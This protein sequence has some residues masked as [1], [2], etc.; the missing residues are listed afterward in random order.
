MKQPNL[1]RSAAFLNVAAKCLPRRR[2]VCGFGVFLVT[3][4][5]VAA[6]PAN[7]QAS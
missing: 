3:V 2:I 1:M 7:L 6:I 4:L 5:I